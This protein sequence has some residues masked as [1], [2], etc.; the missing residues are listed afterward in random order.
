MDKEALLE[1]LLSNQPRGSYWAEKRV[2]RMRYK[3]GEQDT[4]MKVLEGIMWSKTCSM[5]E[6]S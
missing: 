5:R 2:N 1:D 3:C 6:L 4:G